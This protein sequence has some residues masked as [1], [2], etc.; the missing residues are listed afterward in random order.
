MEPSILLV[1][2]GIMHPSLLGRF[3]LRRALPGVR[4]QRVPSLEALPRLVLG[5]FQA[6][7]LYYHHQTVSP[8]ALEAL[9][10]YVRRGG[11]LL[12]VHAATASFRE[13][14]RYFDILGGRFVEHG[15]VET[16][17]VRPVDRDSV[18]GDVP[19][20]SVR[21]ELYHHEMVADVRVG[22]VG[23]TGG[24]PV[25]WT[26]RYERGRVCYCVFGHTVSAVR[27][28]QVQEVLRRGLAWACGGER[29]SSE[30]A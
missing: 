1:S 13:E 16:F 24:V 8:V 21:D 7:V 15:P 4:L 23:G 27:H 19:P 11:G 6:L 29:Q 2:S 3:W 20:F 26:R 28:P 14:S 12:A 17:S 10:T 9:E 18:F 25:V 5:S 30:F 22:M